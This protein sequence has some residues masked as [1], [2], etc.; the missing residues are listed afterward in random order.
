MSR[1]S[2]VKQALVHICLWAAL[3]YG[4]ALIVMACAWIAGISVSPWLPAVLVAI[5]VGL[6]MIILG[7][8]R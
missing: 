7:V 6:G 2:H 3:G 8:M 1:R 5:F 4:F